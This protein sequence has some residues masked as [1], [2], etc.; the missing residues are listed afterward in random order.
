[1]LKTQTVGFQKMVI[2]YIIVK[3]GKKNTHYEDTTI[4]E[5]FKPNGKPG[6]YFIEWKYEVPTSDNISDIYPIE[7]Y[8][9]AVREINTDID[10]STFNEKY[11]N[12]NF[13][14]GTIISFLMVFLVKLQLQVLIEHLKVLIQ[15][16]EVKIY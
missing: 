3:S 15:V 5:K 13:S 12:N 10:I 9:S 6:T 11:V 4:I 16:R 14:V 8:R 7:N 1:M 2:N